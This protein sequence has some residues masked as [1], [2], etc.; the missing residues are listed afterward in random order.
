MYTQ[1]RNKF[2]LIFSLAILAV[3]ALLVSQSAGEF[4]DIGSGDAGGGSAY[5]SLITPSGSLG[6]RTLAISIT[7][8][9]T[10]FIEGTSVL[11]FSGSG[12]TV[13]TST[14]LSATSMAANIS[15]ASGATYGVREVLVTT[16]TESAAG[17]FEIIE[18]VTRPTIESIAPSTGPNNSTTSVTISGTGF[19]TVSSVKLGTYELMSS[20]AVSNSRT[21]RTNVPVGLVPGSYYFSITNSLGTSLSREAAKFIVTQGNIPPVPGS[22]VV[23]DNYEQISG[24]DA[25]G[26]MKGYYPS[27]SDST[28]VG[29]PDPLN[30]LVNV[31]EGLRSMKSLYVGA[32]GAK[33]GGYWGGYLNEG[34]SKTNSRDL[35]TCNVI[36]FQVKG[37]GTQ[38][39]LNLSVKDYVDDEPY[40]AL[41][42]NKLANN[43]SFSQV[44]IPF[45]RLW[46]DRY[47]STVPKVDGT[48]SKK[49]D[50]YT[51]TYKGTIS[52][53][54]Y[55]YI[56]DLK[57]LGWTGPM[58]DLIGPNYGKAG[59]SI[60]LIGSGFGDAKGASAV[61]FSGVA[62]SS[63]VSWTSGK[64][65]VQ[66]PSGVSTGL[67]SVL[68]GTYESN[69]VNFTVTSGTPTDKAKI[70]SIDPASGRSGNIINIQGSAFGGDPGTDR[71]SS[72][73]NHITLGSYRFTEADIVS[74]TDSLIKVA[75]PALTNGTYPLQIRANDNESNFFDFVISSSTGEV[76]PVITLIAPSSG[77]KDKSI[78]IV[79]SGA[80]F[81]GATDVKIG[82]GGFYTSIT[83]FTVVSNVAISCNVDTAREAGTYEVYVMKGSLSSAYSTSALFTVLEAPAVSTIYNFPNPFDPWGGESTKIRIVVSGNMPA[84]LSV[85]DIT[86][87]I[88]MKKSVNL[89]S[90]TN[91]IDWDGRDDFG[92]KVGNG[93]YLLRVVSD[94]KLLG[95][96][97]IWVAAK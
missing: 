43:S 58:V 41:D 53:G 74:W 82:R 86:G 39:T 1:F 20:S 85:F 2:L 27:P 65:I 15:I 24:M 88:L 36:A 87:R 49:I 50:S 79:I 46:Y 14:V 60:T 45:S 16:T 70:T 30:D 34:A 56:D 73:A 96:A 90:G 80:N 9:G 91:D 37:D 12:I 18:P 32:S 57:A 52:N 77:I 40:R 13:N 35:T 62:A 44:K 55:N 72:P 69:A 28:T 31:A 11:S 83:P 95:K 93:V 6:G 75:V 5:L 59:D 51:F 97:K 66:V 7:G 4:F 8:S 89:I 17:A 29:I 10:H 47:A 54:T 25:R 23:I 78:P 94:G 33:W 48:F 81:T 71:K 63:Y 22:A 61:S 68:V 42:S 67:V 84:S 19:L 26:L 64:I 38:N 76:A 21:I 92:G 3:S